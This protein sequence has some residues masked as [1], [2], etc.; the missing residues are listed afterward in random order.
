MPA[1]PQFTTVLLALQEWTDGGVNVDIDL[2]TGLGGGAV[3]AFLTTLLVGAILLALAPEY[4]D[5]TA[6][7]LLAEPVDSF[8]Y[9]IFFLLALVV[10][11]VALVISIVGIL[12]VIPLV[13]LAYLVWAVGS[14]IAFLAIGERLVEAEGR[15]VA[16]LVGALINGGL[17][18]TGVG[19]IISF[20]VGAAGFGIV[21]RQWMDTDGRSAPEV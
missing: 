12:V 21:L 5:R 3:G 20:C 17:T 4:T 11:V 7:S 15:F 19:G 9:G 2:A 16:L 14:S 13:V 18:L 8:L 6:A 1:L 10:M